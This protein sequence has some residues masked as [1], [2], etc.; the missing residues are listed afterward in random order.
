MSVQTTADDYRDRVREALAAADEALATFV[1]EAFV[2]RCWGYDDF[3]D[4]YAGEVRQ[5]LVDLQKIRDA[6]G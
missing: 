5:A 2:R 4:S 1:L 3:R 6:I